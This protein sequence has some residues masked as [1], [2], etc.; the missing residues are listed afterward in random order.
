M[1]RKLV[2]AVLVVLVVLFVNDYRKI[3]ADAMCAHE[4]MLRLM[5][6]HGTEHK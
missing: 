6:T 1:F 5:E 4:N 2:F 3:R